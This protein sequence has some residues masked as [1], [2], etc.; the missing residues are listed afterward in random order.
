M[1]NSFFFILQF[2]GIS[3]VNMN[4]SYNKF[5]TEILNLSITEQEDTTDTG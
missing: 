5:F 1:V 4:I 2:G 3:F